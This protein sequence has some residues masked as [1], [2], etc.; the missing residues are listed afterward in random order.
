MDT[1]RYFIAEQVRS[2]NYS[3]QPMI[4]SIKFYIKSF[5]TIFK[6]STIKNQNEYDNRELKINL[7]Q[8]LILYID[9]VLSNN[10]L[11]SEDSKKYPLNYWLDKIG[12]IFRN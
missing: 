6:K 10:F 9:S 11:N 3:K 5:N 4:N 8:Q 12:R 7:D 1:F 2:V